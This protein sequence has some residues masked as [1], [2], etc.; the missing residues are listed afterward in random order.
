MQKR[1]EY[2]KTLNF[3]REC[4]FIRF[5]LD[6]GVNFWYNRS[7]H[8]W[9]APRRF[10]RMRA[11]TAMQRI[12]LSVCWKPLSAGFR[13]YFSG[14]LEHFKRKGLNNLEIKV[15]IVIPVYNGGELLIRTLDSLCRQTFRD[16]EM[17]VVDDGSTDDTALRLAQYAE[18]EPRLRCFTVPN[19]G[20]SRA[21]N[22]GIE[23][24]KGKYLYLCDAD[25]IPEPGILEKLAAELDRGYTLAACGYFLE[26][27]ED[28]VHRSST[29][30]TAGPLSCE[31]H[32]SFLEALPALMEGQLMYVNWNKMYRMEIIRRAGIT[33]PEQYASCEDRLFNLA[34]FSHV[35]R[36]SMLGEALFHYYIRGTGN[37][38]YKFLPSRYESL[39]RFDTALNALYE[40][41]GRLTGA[42]RE[43]NARIF[44]KGAV[45]C[46]ISL[47]H[48]S[49]TLR[50]E[51]K[52]LFLRE[53]LESATLKNALQN[54]SGGIQFRV[55]GLLLRTGS[56]ALASL[57]GWAGNF[58]GRRLPGLLQKLKGRG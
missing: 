28:G 13:R 42:V 29:P 39:C 54:L 41:G 8:I 53:L 58:A 16:F 21:R 7:I 36:F 57:I 45:A 47:H 19:G 9:P 24:A 4:R 52:R 3:S 44:I 49:C 30:F 11:G 35:E 34:Y 22:F 32:A 51:E 38:T 26:R 2:E 50:R 56:P 55:I 31:N 46:L 10:A 40:A 20:P 33:F 25:D 18:R 43:T 5:F 1:S 27:E 37:L 17:I 14:R 48:P 23:Q 6:S 12:F 15:S